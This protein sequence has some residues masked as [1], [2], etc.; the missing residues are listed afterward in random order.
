MAHAEDGEDVVLAR[1]AAILDKRSVELRS[2]SA[3][4][5]S[6]Y[7][8]PMHQRKEEKEKES[9]SDH[10]SGFVDLQKVPRK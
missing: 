7:A 4:S 6:R 3:T 2:L 8:M 10:L 1:G 9:V 5:G